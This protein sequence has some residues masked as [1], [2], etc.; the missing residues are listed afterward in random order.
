MNLVSVNNLSHTEGGRPL[1]SSIS[2]G[3]DEGQKVALLGRNG[4]GKSTL[5]KIISG[6]KE[7]ESGTAARNRELKCAFLE[8][9]PAFKKDELLAGF[10]LSADTDEISLIR[11]YETISSGIKDD[12]EKELSRLSDI[13]AEMDRLDCWSLESRIHSILSEL[14]IN[15]LSKKMEELSGG[16]VKKAAIARTLVVD[17]NL[18]ILDEPTNHLDIN[19]INWLEKY[20]KASGKA[21]LLVTH[22]RYF[23]DSVCGRIMEI[24]DNTLYIYEGNYTDYVTSRALREN[25]KAKES[26]RINNILRNEAEWIKRGPRARAGKDKKRKERFFDLMNRVEGEK[27]VSA[28]FSVKGKRL[29]GKILELEDIGKKY[30]GINAVDNFTFS[31]R[32]GDKVGIVGANGS[33]KTTL[34]N[35]IAGRIN[36]DSGTVDTGLNTKIGYYD[37]MSKELPG[38]KKVSDYIEETAEVITLNDGKTVSPSQFLEMFLFPKN[39]MYSEISTLSGGEKKKLY[40]LK[41]LLENPNFLIFDEPTN[42]FDLQTLSVLEEF[43]SSFCGCTVIVSHDRF[44]LD[45]TADILFVLDGSGKVRG[46]SGDVSSYCDDISLSEQNS[47]KT[48]AGKSGIESSEI[49][50]NDRGKKTKRTRKGLTYNEKIEFEKIEEDILALEEEKI[51]LEEIFAVPDNDAGISLAETQKRYNTVISLIDEKYSRWEDLES[52]NL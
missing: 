37:Q 25:S 35:I 42:D 11:E 27:A 45:R 12:D 14:G 24:D 49:A 3:I 33:G 17:A 20:L 39:L 23:M 31:F 8:Q 5:L 32:K 16:M 15:D 47:K 30:P 28:A 4:S 10:I 48:A 6:Y 44:F 38:N 7:A 26:D 50:D 46:Y 18:I 52:R 51:E 34:L 43:L 41:I 2:F 19:T 9:T 21:V 36:P 1:F 22:D 29:G 13:M 40:L